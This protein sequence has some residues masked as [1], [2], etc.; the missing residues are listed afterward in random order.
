[1]SLKTKPTA[2]INDSSF[3]DV[4]SID[5]TVDYLKPL[6]PRFKLRKRRKP[7]SSWLTI[8]MPSMNANGVRHVPTLE[9]RPNRQ[10]K[11]EQSKARCYESVRNTAQTD[12][13]FDIAKG[14]DLYRLEFKI[15][16]VFNSTGNAIASVHFGVL[17]TTV[18]Q[19]DNVI[20]DL[21]TGHIHTN[22]PDDP[23]S[24]AQWDLDDDIQLQPYV[25][26]RQGKWL[27]MVDPRLGL[28]SVRCG[29]L[30]DRGVTAAAFAHMRRTLRAYQLNSTMRYV[31]YM[32][33]HKD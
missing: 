21:L 30:D 11:Q 8:V 22:E 4:E 3:V 17:T 9:S 14:N 29:R 5:D 28:T 33:Y 10:F 1:M 32:R 6:P 15:S 27:Y 26:N 2:M 19:F 18:L 23:S 31:Y 16:T 13:T 12:I 25:A 24:P 20:S 7:S